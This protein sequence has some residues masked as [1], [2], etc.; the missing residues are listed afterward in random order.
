MEK[1]KTLTKK[2]LVKYLKDSDFVFTE[3]GDYETNV[4]VMA[5]AVQFM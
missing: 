3:F 5:D 4:R 2:D 1:E